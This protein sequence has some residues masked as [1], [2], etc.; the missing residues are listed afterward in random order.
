MKGKLIKLTL[1]FIFII[2]IL[3]VNGDWVRPKVTEESLGLDPTA[4]NTMAI[5]VE[6]HFN[7]ETVHLNVSDYS[8]ETYTIKVRP[9]RHW[10]F[11]GDFI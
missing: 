5:N 2:F 9:G 10:V 4:I 7:Q 1:L 8:N 6:N 11:K 3:N